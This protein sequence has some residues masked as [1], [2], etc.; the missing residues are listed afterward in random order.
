ME[1][2]QCKCSD[3]QPLQAGINCCRSSHYIEDEELGQLAQVLR[4]GMTLWKEDAGTEPRILA[5]GILH[6]LSR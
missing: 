6:H 3:K 1:S 5:Y 4:F 2:D